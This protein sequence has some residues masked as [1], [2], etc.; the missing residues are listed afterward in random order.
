[1]SQNDPNQI[2]DTLLLHQ[3]QQG[4][5]RAFDLLFEKYWQQAYSTAYK[6]LK[7]HDEAKDIVQEIFTHIW[8]NRQITLIENL[9]AY[10]HVAVRNRVIKIISKQRPT[11]FFFEAMDTISEKDLCADSPLL[12][13]EFMKTY[14][15]LLQTLPPKRQKIF[16][17]HYEEDLSTKE[18]SENMG[19]NRKTVQNQLT[20]AVET[21]KI[22][23]LRILT[24]VILFLPAYFR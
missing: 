20:K 8:M 24:I 17:L 4:S 14:E 21:L 16:K 18:I 1:M 6:R 22:S 19:I 9:P 2:S 12:W 7:S 13:K 5:T 3:M 10:L 23:L 11:H 15:A